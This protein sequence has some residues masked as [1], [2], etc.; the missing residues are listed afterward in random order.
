LIDQ[1]SE[2]N[3][4]RGKT[5]GAMTESKHAKTTAKRAAVPLSIHYYV[6]SLGEHASRLYEGFRDRLIDIQNMDFPYAFSPGEPSAGD[7][8]FHEFLEKTDKRFARFYEQDPL[9]VVVA[10]RKKNLSMFESVTTHQ[11]AFVAVVEGDYAR[12]SPHDMGKIVW[13]VVKEAMAGG[14]KKAMHD[15]EKAAADQKVA[16][17]IDSV[18]QSV[19][20]GAGATLFVEE[21]YH[22]KGSLHEAGPSLVYSRDVD[23]REVLDDAVDVLIEKVLEGGGNVVFLDGGSLIEYQRIAMITRE[24]AA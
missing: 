5:G 15:L 10:G 23:I 21:N 14:R 20:S 13:P 17:G 24:S 19:E 6:L 3:A 4:E 22:V 12:T 9:R 16:S 2:N 1:V 7:E 8:P 11:E 18:T